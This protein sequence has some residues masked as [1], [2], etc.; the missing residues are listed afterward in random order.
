MRRVVIGLVLV[1]L[2]ITCLPGCPTTNARHNASQMAVVKA[3]L[4]Y[5]HE[6]WDWFWML[7]RPSRLHLSEGVWRMGE[8]P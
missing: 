1:G 4:G 6:N 2:V 5:A 7:D 3:N 8:Q